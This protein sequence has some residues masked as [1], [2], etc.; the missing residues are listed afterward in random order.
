MKTEFKVGLGF[1]ICLA[2]LLA[3]SIAPS[4]FAAI[5]YWDNNGTNAGFGTAGGTW[6]VPTVGN[7]ST[8]WSTSS[9]GTVVLGKVT[10]NAADDLNFGTASL[11]LGAGTVTTSSPFVIQDAEVTGLPKR[12]YRFSTP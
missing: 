2:A 12:F 9:G 11:A 10:I 5:Y 7:A 8:G 4:A 3:C 1:V 6:A